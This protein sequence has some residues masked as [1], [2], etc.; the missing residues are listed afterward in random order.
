MVV[1]GVLFLALALLTVIA[2]G[3]G[4]FKIPPLQVIAILLNQIGIAPIVPF[5]PEQVAV[6]T[7]IRL[8]RVLL[9]ILVGA[10][11]AISG[12]AMQGLFRNPLADPSL[13]GVSSGAALAAAAVIVMGSL[14]FPGLTKNGWDTDVAVDVIYRRG[15]RIAD[16]LSLKRGRRS[17]IARGDAARGHRHIEPG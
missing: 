12:A 1:F 3:S 7:A 14:W 4:G 9:A 15:G 17:D 16:C 8:P 10:G 2:I 5:A 11:L 6:L 13:L